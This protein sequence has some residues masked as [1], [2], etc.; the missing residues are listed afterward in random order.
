MWLVSYFGWKPPLL[1]PNHL[2]S[3]LPVSRWYVNTRS[4]H[5]RP[6]PQTSW[7]RSVPKLIPRSYPSLE[8]T[9]F[10]RILDEKSPLFQPKSYFSLCLIWNEYLNTRPRSNIWKPRWNRQIHAKCL[11]LFKISPIYGSKI[12]LFVDFA[13]SRLP[14]KNWPFFR[15]SRY[16]RGIRFDRKLGAGRE[17]GGMV[18]SHG[19]KNTP[20]RVPGAN[21]GS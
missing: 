3:G 13:D 6:K 17:Q 5:S 2:T 21:P 15:E 20:C 4:T 18:S 10:S 8:N 1:I 11:P 7:W 16:E 19:E 9:P 12:P 14:L